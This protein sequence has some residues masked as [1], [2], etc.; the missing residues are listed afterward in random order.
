MLKFGLRRLGASTNH[1]FA[2][3]IREAR[4]AT[5]KR[6]LFSRFKAKT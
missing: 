3:A 2:L 5:G 1:D 4:T 6:N